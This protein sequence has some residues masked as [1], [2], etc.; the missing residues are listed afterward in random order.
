M[1]ISSFNFLRS[2]K[3]E[4]QQFGVIGLGRFGRAVCAQLHESGYEVLAIDKEEKKVCQALLDQ[5]ASHALQLDTTELSALKESGV[6]D[7]DIIIVA[8][9]NFLA[10]SITTT[11]NV[12][13]YLDQKIIDAEKAGKKEIPKKRIVA[14]ASS[15]THMKILYKVG[16]DEVIFPEDDMGRELA[17]R[18]ITRNRILDLFEVDP[19]HSVVEMK[20]PEEFFGKTIRELDLRNKYGLNLLAVRVGSDETTEINPPANKRFTP[21]MEMIVL[22]SNQSIERLFK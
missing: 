15:E 14:K 12:K 17:Q 19:E 6:F 5:I 10:E 13:E 9:G 1:K 18:L 16:A 3:S 7:C 11:L 21:G 4:K 20:V 8:I 22:S 2:L